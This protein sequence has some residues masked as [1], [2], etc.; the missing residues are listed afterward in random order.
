MRDRLH[1]LAD[2]RHAADPLEI[3]LRTEAIED[4]RGVDPLAA[5][6]EVE[7]VTEEHL[8]GFVGEVLGAEDE[9][10]VVAD[11]RLEEE[12]AEDASLG[13]QVEGALAE[14]DRAGAAVAAITGSLPGAVSLAVTPVPIPAVTAAS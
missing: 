12:A 2:S 14:I 4:D 6:V 3:P 13:G 5:V 10:D 11:V 9:R 1:D 8:M 7:E